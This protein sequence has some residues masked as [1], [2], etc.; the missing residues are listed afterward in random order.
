MSLY[1]NL[2]GKPVKVK[3]ELGISEPYLN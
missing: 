1:K 3:D 2:G